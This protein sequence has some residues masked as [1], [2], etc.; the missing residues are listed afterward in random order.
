M[1]P[2]PAAALAL[3][4]KHDPL[5]QAALNAPLADTDALSP[6]ELAGLD[7]GMADIL[8]GRTVSHDDIRATI[9]QMRRDQGE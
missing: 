6:E 7:E 8:A 2:R 1:A 9:E 5:W 3:D 4:S